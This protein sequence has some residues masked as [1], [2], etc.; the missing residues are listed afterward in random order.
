LALQ[1]RKKLNKNRLYRA[2]DKP[3]QL[4]KKKQFNFN[5]GSAA[6]EARLPFARMAP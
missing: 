2:M 4:S 5:T 3:K 6:A 1:Q